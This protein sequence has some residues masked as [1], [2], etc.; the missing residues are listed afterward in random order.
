M[1]ERGVS[2]FGREDKKDGKK[3]KERPKGDVEAFLG[4]GSTFEGRLVFEDIVRLDGNFSGE[5]VSRG[6]LIIGAEADVKAELKVDT[7]IMSGEFRGD[8]EAKSRVVL[9]APA[10]V[11]G[12]ITTPVL[13]V[14]EGVT[15]DGALVMTRKDTSGKLP[16]AEISEIDSDSPKLQSI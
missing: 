15:I 8:I 12:N 9:K 10:K 5:I 4:A 6:T 16:E 1:V 2:V 13:S 3:E 14:E 11:A 7:L